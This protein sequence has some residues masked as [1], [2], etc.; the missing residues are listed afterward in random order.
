MVSSIQ[1]NE[2]VKRELERLKEKRNESYEDV[3]VKLIDEK[4][5][6]RRLREQFLAE[7]YKEMA[8]E[9]LK[10]AKEWED[11]LMDGMD[12]DESWDEYL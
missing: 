12:K 3:I 1:L 4:E 10:I 2:H 7:S 11:T 8:V 6:Q 5:N 9:D